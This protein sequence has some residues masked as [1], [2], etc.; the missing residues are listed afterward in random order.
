[1]CA[2][3][4]AIVAAVDSR[5]DNRHEGLPQ[6]LHMALVPLAHVEVQQECASSIVQF[7]RGFSHLVVLSRKLIDSYTKATLRYLGLRCTARQAEEKPEDQQAGKRKSH[8]I[9]SSLVIAAV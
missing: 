9:Y 5:L 8:W 2:D 1:M 3:G 7:D 6:R 4:N